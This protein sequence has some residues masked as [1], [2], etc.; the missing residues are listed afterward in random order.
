MNYYCLFQSLPLNEYPLC[1]VQLKMDQS[2]REWRDR[3]R[4]SYTVAKA[5]CGG[6][7]QLQVEIELT[8][9]WLIRVCQTD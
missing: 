4:H 6:R 9:T 5:P 2:L 8:W 7:I 1:D 3:H